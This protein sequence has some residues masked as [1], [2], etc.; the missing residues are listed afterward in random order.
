VHFN[1]DSSRSKWHKKEKYLLIWC[2]VKLTEKRNIK[3]KES[4][5]MRP[6]FAF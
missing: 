3:F 4:V 1:E 6:K 5:F 2:V